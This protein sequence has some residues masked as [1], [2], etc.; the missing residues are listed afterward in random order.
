MTSAPDSLPEA[1]IAPK[2]ETAPRASWRGALA[3]YLQPRVL[4]VLLLGFSSG[5]PLALSG[6]AR[7]AGVL[8]TAVDRRHPAAGADRPSALAVVRGAR[9]AVGRGN[10]VDPGHC[11]RC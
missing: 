2:P 11:G 4:I 8:A 7:L 3:V 1:S 10:V 5:L 9:R 6:S